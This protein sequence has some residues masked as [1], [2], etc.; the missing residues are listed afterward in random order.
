MPSLGLGG[1]CCG[2]F[3]RLNVI[4]I[5]ATNEVGTWA[6]IMERNMF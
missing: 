5:V 3:Y 4:E 2:M 1:G 6:Q